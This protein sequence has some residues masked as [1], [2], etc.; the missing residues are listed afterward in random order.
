[1]LDQ[2]AE[3]VKAKVRK[4]F[5]PKKM[6]IVIV[7]GADRQDQ[8]IVQSGYF[9]Q[10]KIKRP[11]QNIIKE[12][13]SA[14]AARLLELATGVV[15]FDHEVVIL[16]SVGS[17][18]HKVSYV[19]WFAPESFALDACTQLRGYVRSVQEQLSLEHEWMLRAEARI[20]FDL[21]IKAEETYLSNQN[22]GT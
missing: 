11:G 12:T 15:P 8:Y 20:A 16:D 1:M 17:S 19:F 4:R 13:E 5:I 21:F 6:K 14:A 22:Q 9:A 18:T 2:L 10:Q 7:L 3:R